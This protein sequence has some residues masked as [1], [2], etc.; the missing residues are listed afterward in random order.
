MTGG[1]CKKNLKHSLMERI[2]D[3]MRNQH[4]EEE[5][6]KR[7]GVGGGLNSIKGIGAD[8]YLQCFTYA[9]DMVVGMKKYATC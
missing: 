8:W 1:M 9:Y 5:N 7:Q 6:D 4:V 2:E 3:L